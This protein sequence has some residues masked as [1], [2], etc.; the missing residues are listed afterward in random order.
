MRLALRGPVDPGP[1]SMTRSTT[2]WGPMTPI[3][4]SPVRWALTSGCSPLPFHA[5][6]YVRPLVVRPDLCHGMIAEIVPIV[7]GQGRSFS[8]S[9]PEARVGGAIPAQVRKP[10]RELGMTA[11]HQISGRDDCLTF[12]DQSG[13]DQGRTCPQVVGDDLGATQF[14]GPVHDRPGALDLDLGT[15]LVQ[16]VGQ[17][18][19]S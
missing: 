1:M 14:G 19:A 2:S 10:C 6:H 3:V 4:K 9:T 17:G 18:E 7:R 5:L 12:G 11:V 8:T 16:L 15:H 13:E